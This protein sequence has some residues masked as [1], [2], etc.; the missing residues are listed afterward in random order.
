MDIL[1][2]IKEYIFYNWILILILSAFAI[3]LVITSFLDKKAEKRLFTLIIIVLLLS[4]V[5]FAEYRISD[6]TNY[7]LA[8]KILIAIRYSATPFI[9]AHVIY[10]LVR[11]IRPF[12][13]IPAGVLLLLDIIS[14]P[15]GILFTINESTNK[16]VHFP[17]I[18]YLPYIIAGLYCT[19]LIYIL[20]AR[21]NKR[22]MEIVPIIFLAVAFVSGV[23]FPFIYESQFLLIF[24]TII[25][26]ALFVY[27]VFSI[28]QLAKKD[29]LTGL[30]NRQ[31]YYGEVTDYSKDITAIISLDMNGLKQLNDTQ[32][33][34]AGDEALVV[35]SVC[36]VRA[37][38]IRQS[39]YR[40]GGDEFAIVCRKT[41][42]EEVVKL[43]ERINKYVDET[44]YSVS[45]G[46]SY[47]EPG[48]IKTDDLLKASDESMYSNKADYYKNKDRRNN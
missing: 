32:G 41:T 30:L 1:D 25:A 15:T 13:Y 18:G 7:V 8:R 5:F 24:C 12:V 2:I 23:A 48:T 10:T 35:L 44:D 17:V 39:V 19:F 22:A 29:A 34:A 40:M 11:R 20:I 28:L 14:V 3:I 9:L 43:I 6:N 31:A 45:I 38:K 37:C 46:Y 16:L 27:Y 36:F 47:H 4:I 33:H 21:S 26:V 42:E